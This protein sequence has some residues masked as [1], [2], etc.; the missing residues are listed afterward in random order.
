MG[1]RVRRFALHSAVVVAVVLLILLVAASV[2]FAGV[3]TAQPAGYPY[4]PNNRVLAVDGRLVTLEAGTGSSVPGSRWGLRSP[5]GYVRML[6]LVELGEDT[7]TWRTSGPSRQRPVIGAVVRV[8]EYLAIGDPAE[9]RGL[10]FRE[11][12]VDGPLGEQPSWLVPAVGERVGT[13]VYVHGSGGTREEANRFLPAM[14][15]SGWDVLVPTYRGDEGAP[16]A[17]GNRR[18]FGTT[19]WEDVEAAV[20]LVDD[21][22]GALVLFGSSMGGAVV[23]QLLDRSAL[24]PTVDGVVLD[25]PL[26]SLDAAIDLNAARNGIPRFAQPVLVPALQVA[27]DLRYGIGTGALEQVEDDGTFGVPTLVLHGDADVEAPIESSRELAALVDTVRLE[28]FPDAGHLV[29]WNVDRSRYTRLLREHL[30]AVAG[31]GAP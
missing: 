29:A 4:G 28:E 7:V 21:R 12:V 10:E 18:T 26:L 17:P 23:A 22:P 1:D 13:V 2:R 6:E 5:N 3:L 31:G 30:A 25:S 11:V 8:D 15:N 24:A 14:V 27:A 9:A 19:E 16:P 20:D